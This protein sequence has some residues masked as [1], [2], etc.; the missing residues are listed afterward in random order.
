MTSYIPQS[1][2]RKHQGQVSSD[3]PLEQIAH[4]LGAKNATAPKGNEDKELFQLGANSLTIFEVK[5]L[6]VKNLKEGQTTKGE[7]KN[8]LSNIAF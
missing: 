6:L 2:G 7:V 3:E 5:Q 8:L 1:Q 4:A